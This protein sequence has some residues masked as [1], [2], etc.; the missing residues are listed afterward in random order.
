V[1]PATAITSCARL[2]GSFMF[3]SFNLKLENAT[4]GSAVFSDLANEKGPGLMSVLGR[5]LSNFGVN[6]DPQRLQSAQIED[7]DLSFLETLE[8]VQDEAQKIMVQTLQ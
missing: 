4:P 2:A 5:S 1:H 8:R 6:P 3:R 7:S